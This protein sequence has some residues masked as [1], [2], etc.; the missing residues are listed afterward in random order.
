MS[1][2]TNI[3][4]Y[5]RVKKL[6]SKK[7]GSKSG[8][9]RSSWIVKEY[10]KKS[11]KYSGKKN[12]KSGLTRWFKENWVDLNRPIKNHGKIIGY[13]KCGRKNTKD[14]SKYPLCRPSKRISS[15]TPKTYKE[16][17]KE[18]IKKAKSYKSKIKQRGNVQF[19]KGTQNDLDFW[20]L[21][22][23]GSILVMCFL[24]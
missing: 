23:L 5:K 10:K 20:S 12:K 14:S 4:L 6:A 21:I 16:I 15:K 18:S 1:Q 24:K 2:P 22:G 11:G 8:I 9:Y 19:G 3:E 17:S 13:Q 7:F